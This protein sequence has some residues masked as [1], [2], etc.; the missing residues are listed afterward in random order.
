M[1]STVID[2]TNINPY[3]VVPARE[4]VIFPYKT[5]NN[6]AVLYSQKELESNF[7][8]VWNYLNENKKELEGR[9]KGKMKG[10][11]WYAYVY[12]KNLTKQNSSKIL[13]PHVVKKAIS[14]FD[15]KGEFC[16]DNVGAN[17][18]ILKE[19]TKESPY[20]IIAILNS[21]IASFFISKISIF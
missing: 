15:E 12:P 8:N 3:Y 14:A 20:Y 17:G 18:I 6:K 21:L 13:I 2:N 10:I 5:E 11:E 19:E 7:P 1:L 16:L 4:Y 9:E